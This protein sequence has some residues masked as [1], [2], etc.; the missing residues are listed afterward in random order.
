[1]YW[2]CTGPNKGASHDHK[3]RPVCPAP[4]L[5][6]ANDNATILLDDSTTQLRDRRV[7]CATR[8]RDQADRWIACRQ[9][10]TFAV[11]GLAIVG[12][13][14]CVASVGCGLAVLGVAGGGSVMVGSM[15]AGVATA[16]IAGGGIAGSLDIMMQNAASQLIR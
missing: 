16:A 7:H 3:P 2:L 1:V 11:V 14:A 4:P 6:K 15:T 5:R 8:S 10:G 12:T 13:V 9:V